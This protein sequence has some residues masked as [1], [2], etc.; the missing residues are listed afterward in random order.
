M[1]AAAPG[2]SRPRWSGGASPRPGDASAT[3]CANGACGRVCAQ[4]VRTAQDAGRRG[5]AR[6]H[7]RP[8]VRRLRAA[9]PPGRWPDVRAR[10]RRVGVRVPAGRPGEQGHYRPQRRHGPHRR[11]GHGRVRHARLPPDR[12]GGVPHGPGRRVRRRENRRAARRVR[13]R[14]IAVREGRPVRQRRGRIHQQAPEEGAHIPEPPHRPGT[15]TLRPQRLCVVVRRPK[16]PLHPRIPEPQ[17]IHTTRT[18]PLKN[19]PT[20]RCQSRCRTSRRDGGRVIKATAR[21]LRPEADGADFGGPIGRGIPGPG[22]CHG[23]CGPRATPH[24][25]PVPAPRA[26]AWFMAPTVSPSAR[27]ALPCLAD[28]WWRSPPPRR[29]VLFHL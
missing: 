2:R 28:G 12:G 24:G 21:T 20:H 4:T 27:G 1:S 18:R 3:S 29:G 23:V 14:R 25:L 6:E 15:T 5:R 8:R 10:R 19:C 22:T 11:P 16:T 17:R 13:H 26:A 7:P 9:H